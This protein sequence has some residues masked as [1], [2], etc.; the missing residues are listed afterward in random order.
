ML[1]LKADFGYD[2]C[3]AQLDGLASDVMIAQ[4]ALLSYGGVI[5]FVALFG[6]NRS[7]THEID[8]EAL[9]AKSGPCPDGRC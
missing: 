8:S 4:H 9:E 1:N 2:S 5:A 7:E 6:V 3:P